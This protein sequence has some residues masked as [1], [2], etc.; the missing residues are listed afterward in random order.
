[1]ALS[2]AAQVKAW[3]KRT[4]ATTVKVMK[5]A[6]ADLGED[7]Q[8]PVSEGGYMP[9]LT[10]ELRDSLGGS[11]NGAAIATG[12]LS[13]GPTAGAMKL[14]DVA[15][16]GWSAEYASSRH[17]RGEDYGQGGGLWRDRS[18]RKWQSIVAAAVEMFRK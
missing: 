14:G 15:H 9:V 11:L 10:S 1:M 18:A 2:Y 6:V 12:P 8:T 17:Y 16:L 5:R 7:A 4:R 13:Y 3:N